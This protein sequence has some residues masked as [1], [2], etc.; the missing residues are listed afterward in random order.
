MYLIVYD[1]EIHDT[2]YKI[3]RGIP[4]NKKVGDINGYG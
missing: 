4:I 3:Y 1:T 2:I